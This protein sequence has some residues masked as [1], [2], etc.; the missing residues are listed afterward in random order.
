MLGWEFY[1]AWFHTGSPQAPDK[2]KDISSLE[3]SG[4]QKKKKNSP[5][6]LK[7]KKKKVRYNKEQ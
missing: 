2:N 6:K 3:K 1:L 7:K 4:T 5:Q